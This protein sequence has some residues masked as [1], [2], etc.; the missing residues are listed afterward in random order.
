MP[1]K[2]TKWIQLVKQ[3]YAKGKKANNNYKFSTALKDAKK[4]Y[5]KK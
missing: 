4:V 5:T 2:Q 1:K 3:T